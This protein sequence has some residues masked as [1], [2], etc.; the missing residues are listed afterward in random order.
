MA[1]KIWTTW[2][3]KVTE[4]TWDKSGARYIQT[5]NK[6]WS[7]RLDVWRKA[8]ENDDHTDCP[9]PMPYGHIMF[10]GKLTGYRPVNF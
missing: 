4:R 2:D 6:D 3:G 8:I 10:N 1:H 7:V 5:T 9:C